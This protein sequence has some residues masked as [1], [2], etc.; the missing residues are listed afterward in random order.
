MEIP[1]PPFLSV[2]S[3]STLFPELDAVQP[4]EVKQ[5][6]LARC[7]CQR[8]AW[9]CQHARP[10]ALR[11]L[12]DRR[13][14]SGMGFAEAAF[15]EREPLAWLRPRGLSGPLLGCVLSCCGRTAAGSHTCPPAG[16]SARGRCSARVDG[17]RE[18]GCRR[19]SQGRPVRPVMGARARQSPGRDPPGPR[20]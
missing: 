13:G 14:S 18:R 5:S 3:C 12:K 19:A 11:H 6:L 16:F 2:D 20:A 10:E 7:F 4:G 1:P 15:P 8:L 17:P 9:T